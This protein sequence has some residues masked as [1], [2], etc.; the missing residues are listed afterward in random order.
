[1][2]LLKLNKTAR[3]L[4]NDW[5]HINKFLAEHFKIAV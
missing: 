3:S 1:M 4:E 2:Y 5:A